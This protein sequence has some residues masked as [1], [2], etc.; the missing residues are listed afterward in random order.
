M[1]CVAISLLVK[2]QVV[3]GSAGGGACDQVLT[4]PTPAGKEGLAKSWREAYPGDQEKGLGG[5]S[6]ALQ[7]E[8]G[9][10]RGSGERPIQG[11][12]RKA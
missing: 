4:L 2:S 12:R 1:A 7:G 10:S 5:P 6:P 11:I 8:E 3:C 9:L